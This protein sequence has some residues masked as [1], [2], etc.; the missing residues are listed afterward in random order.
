VTPHSRAAACP[1]CDAELFP[2]AAA[3][4]D[5]PAPAPA[6]EDDAAAGIEVEAA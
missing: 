6:G 4:G 1:Y 3:P 5:A 2:R